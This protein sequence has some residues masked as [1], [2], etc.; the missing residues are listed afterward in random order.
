MW[1]MATAGGNFAKN[2]NVLT[3]DGSVKVSRLQWNAYWAEP[4]GAK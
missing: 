2:V 1:N 3:K 4:I